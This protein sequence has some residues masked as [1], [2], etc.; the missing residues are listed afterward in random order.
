MSVARN[1]EHGIFNG[2]LLEA[3]VRPL[4]VRSTNT[5]LERPGIIGRPKDSTYL[6]FEISYALGMCR[7]RSSLRQQTVAKAKP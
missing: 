2:N 4:C 3:F 1:R 6:P 7:V 5:D